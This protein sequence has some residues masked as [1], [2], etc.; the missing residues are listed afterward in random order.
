[1][2]SEEVCQLLRK[3]GAAT[4]KTLYFELL[5]RPGFRLTHI[6]KVLVIAFLILTNTS[7]SKQ[8][9]AMHYK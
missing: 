9:T 7:L 4:E 1:M 3:E 8:D 2:D 5:L 6:D